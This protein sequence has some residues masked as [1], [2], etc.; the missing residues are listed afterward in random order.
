MFLASAIQRSESLVGI[1]MPIVAP[2]FDLTSIC[3]E[4]QAARDSAR[5]MVAKPVRVLRTGFLQWGARVAGPR[6][7][8]CY[9]WNSCWWYKC[10]WYKLLLVIRTNR[11]DGSA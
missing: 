3:S 6:E 7:S 10:W 9:R 8:C 1:E 11:A 4:P 5:L 2:M